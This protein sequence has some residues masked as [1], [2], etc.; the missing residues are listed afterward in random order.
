MLEQKKRELGRFLSFINV[1]SHRPIRS[2]EILANSKFLMEFIKTMDK[3]HYESMIQIIWCS[4]SRT[5][6]M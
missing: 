6:R 5:D 2:D 4:A 3:V 1:L